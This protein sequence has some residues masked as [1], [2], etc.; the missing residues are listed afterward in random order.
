MSDP[1]GE[2]DLLVLAR[3]LAGSA[4]ANEQVEAYAVRSR[5]TEVKAHAGEVESLSQATIAG[6]GI[7]VVVDHRQG[8][9]WAGTLHDGDVAEML[10]EARDNA[11]YGE[12]DQWNGLVEPSEIGEVPIPDLDL[13]NDALVNAPTEEK[14]RLAL[15]IEAATRSADSRVRGVEAAE[16][17]DS[18]LEAAIATSTGIEAYVRRTTCSCYSFA[19]A[20]EGT[21]TQTGYGFTVGRS[22]ADL[23]I[24]AAARDAAMRATRLLGA[25]QPA[26]R[27][28]AV[29]FDPLVTASFL[30]VLSSALSAES[31]LKGRSLFAERVGEQV[32]ATAVSIIEDPTIAQAFGAGAYDS[33]G[34]PTRR[35]ELIGNGVLS[36]FLQNAYTGRRSGAG[37]TGSAARGGFSS[38]PGVGARALHLLPGAMSPEEIMALVPEALY[39]QSVSGLHS[40]TNPISGDF[41]VGAEGL[42]VR[43]GSF[44]EP[45]REVTIASTLQR[46]LLDVAQVG[47]DIQWL[48]GGAAGCTLL[49][50]EMTLSGA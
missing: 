45:V 40:G 34:V 26:S 30:G 15:E 47:A 11:T 6:V 10:E 18:I 9:A 19:M 31:V 22:I 12:P 25:R 44:A 14:V 35:V 48:P 32:A 16:Y 17:G 28:I 46:M 50:G 27:K 21:E 8:F 43:G 1:I 33:E 24:A 7:R 41:S 38:T 5:E 3:A 39:V 4:R 13:W 49:V 42:M 23:D 2:Q 20:G 37:T 29:I 36:G